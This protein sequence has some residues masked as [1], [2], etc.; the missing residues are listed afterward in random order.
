MQVSGGDNQMGGSEMM[1]TLPTCLRNGCSNP[2]VDSP[3]WDREYC[4]SECVVSHCK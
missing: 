2:A 1:S 3:D 4:S